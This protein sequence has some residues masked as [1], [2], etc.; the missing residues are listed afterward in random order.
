[1]RKLLFTIMTVLLCANFATFAKKAKSPK[2]AKVVNATNKVELID[3]QGAAVGIELPNWI[4]AAASGNN[5]AVIADLGLKEDSQVFLITR[6]GDDLDFLKTW[7]DQ[8]DVRGEAVNAIETTISQCVQTELKSSS[9]IEQE[10]IDRTANLY[11]AQMTNLTLNG[12]KKCAQYWTKTRTLKPGLKRGKKEEDYNYRTTYYAVFAM[13]GKDFK[14]QLK[15]AMDDVPDND[16]QTSFLRQLLTAKVS[17]VLMP[18]IKIDIGT[19]DEDEE[20]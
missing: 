11:S 3:H 5:S 14:T 20:D 4:K 18:N 2:A 12:L 19:T 10:K 13:D 16:D 15:A 9:N 6:D 7:A 1:M 8:I 17:S